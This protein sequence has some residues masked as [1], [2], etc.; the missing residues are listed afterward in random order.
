MIGLAIVA[1]IAASTQTLARMTGCASW[2]T[3]MALVH[4]KNASLI[5]PAQVDRSRTKTVLLASEKTGRDLVREIYDITFVTRSGA[6][7]EVVTRSEASREEC[8]MGGVDVYVVSR[9]LG[10]P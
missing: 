1:T 8:S 9:K 5:D 6:T 7:V 4:L 2:P 10:G 3:N